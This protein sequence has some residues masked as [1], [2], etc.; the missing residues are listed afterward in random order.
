[1]ICSMVEKR[2]RE[3]QESFRKYNWG[4]VLEERKRERYENEDTRE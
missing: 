4:S 3:K 2:G 1:M